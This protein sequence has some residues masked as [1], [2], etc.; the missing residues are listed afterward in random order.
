M[1]NLVSVGSHRSTQLISIFLKCAV[2]VGMIWWLL[3]SFPIGFSFPK[4]TL[5]VVFGLIVSF[6]LMFVQLLLLS[7]RWQIVTTIIEDQED[8]RQN[9]WFFFRT[10]WLSMAVSQVLPALIAGDA[11][12]IG[13][14]KLIGMRVAVATRSVLIDRIIGLIGLTFLTFP[15]VAIIC[16]RGSLAPKAWLYGLVFLAVLVASL[17]VVEQRSKFRSRVLAVLSTRL[18]SYTNTTGLMV[19]S[20]SLVGHAISVFIFVSLASSFGLEI[21]LI[22]GFLVFPIAL[23]AAMLPFSFG[24]WGVR[25]LAVAH[26]MVL[27]EKPEAI[28]LQASIIFGMFQFVSALPSVFLWLFKKSNS[29]PI[30]GTPKI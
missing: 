7:R 11:M 5:P 27:F 28:G 8:S 12:R 9:F 4:L 30:I 15:A 26:A 2:S 19:L 3:K 18:K 23:F 25:E 29:R 13:A 10:T 16:Y 24:G 22:D 21:S 14:L 20:L 6:I 1:L 17:A